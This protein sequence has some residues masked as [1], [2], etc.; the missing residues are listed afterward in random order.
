ML[1]NCLG[2]TKNYGKLAPPLWAVNKEYVGE[3]DV[4]VCFLLFLLCF[5]SYSLTVF[6]M[7]GVHVS[8]VPFP[9]KKIGSPN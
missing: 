5:L 4:F 6:H 8:R 3:S 1:R 2:K 7:K 9:P